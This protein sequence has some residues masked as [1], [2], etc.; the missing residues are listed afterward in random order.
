MANENP[1]TPTARPATFVRPTFEELYRSV[2]EL[3]PDELG[4]LG[5]RVDVEDVVHDVVILAYRRLEDFDPHQTSH[6]RLALR[7]WIRAIAW[8]HIVKRDK[9]A[10]HYSALLDSVTR[11]SRMEEPPTAEDI[12][13]AAERHSILVNVLAKLKP[14]RAEVFILHAVFELSVQ[15]IACKLGLNKNTVKSRIIRARSEARRAIERLPCEV[16][17]ALDEGAP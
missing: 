6:P 12:A 4:R 9:R 13:A 1:I 16:R 5:V 15:D 17:S 10:R 2:R 14:L 11:A 7:A 8:Y 3:L